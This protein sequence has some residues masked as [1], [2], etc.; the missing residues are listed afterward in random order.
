MKE[1]FG[2][3][4]PFALSRQEEK[5]KFFGEVPKEKGRVGYRDFAYKKIFL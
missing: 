3:G 4:K 5:D 2:R 1:S